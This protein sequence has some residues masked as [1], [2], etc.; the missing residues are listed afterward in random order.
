LEKRVFNKTYGND[1]LASRVRRLEKAVFPSDAP[2]TFSPTAQRI[3]RLKSAVQPAIA[4]AGAQQQT[5]HHFLHK[6]GKFLGGVGTIA[7]E[8]LGSAV[9]AGGM[10]M[11]MGYGM[12]GYGYGGPMG[13]GYPGRF[14][15]MY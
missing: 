13:F 10:G 8:A 14:M 3:A 5:P 15:G 11:G 12:G 4:G 9:A 2:G 7:G 6:L 1:N